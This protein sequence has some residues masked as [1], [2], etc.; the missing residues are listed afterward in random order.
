MQNSITRLPDDK[1]AIPAGVHALD[2]LDLLEAEALRDL[3]AAAT[4]TLGGGTVTVRR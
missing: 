4:D 1:A 3:V 2:Q